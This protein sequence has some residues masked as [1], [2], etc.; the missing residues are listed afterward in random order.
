MAADPTKTRRAAWDATLGA[1]DLGGVDSV[2]PTGIKMMLDPVKIGSVGKMKID[3][4]F[5]GCTDDSQIKIVVR[6]V[7]RVRMEKLCPWFVGTTLVTDINGTPPVN[8]LIANAYAQELRLH[9]TDKGSTIN[10]DLVFFKVVP[11]GPAAL[12]KRTG[13]VD[14]AWEITLNIYPDLTKLPA[15]PYFQVHA[16]T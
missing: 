5:V 16:S 7:T 4:R 15:N 12:I 2:D 3:D 6:E 11:V 14:D 13:T 10:E 9:P 8:T 1:H